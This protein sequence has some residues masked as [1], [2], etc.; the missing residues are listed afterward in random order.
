MRIAILGAGVAGLTCAHIL[1]REHEVTVFEAQ[2]RVGGHTHTHD[3]E[4]EGQ[5][6]RV[7]TGF[8]VFNEPNYPTFLRLLNAL[9]VR[10]RETDMSFSVRCD[11]TGVEWRGSNLNTLFAQRLNLLRPSFLGM[12]RDA[13]RFNRE[14]RALATTPPDD[15]LTVGRFIEQGRYG[16]G[17]LDLYLGPLGSSLWSCPPDRFREFPIR[18]VIDFLHNHDMLRFQGQPVWRTI[19]GGSDS[20]IEPLTR[21]Y[22]ERIRT[23]A[24]VTRVRRD[25][26]GVDV[27]STGGPGRYDELVL[28]CHADEAAAVLADADAGEREMLAAFPYQLNDVVLHT[29]PTLMPRR[30][31][32]WAA[33]NYHVRRGEDQPATVTYSMNIL[34]GI[35]SRR[36]LLVT[37]NETGS[38]EPSRVLRRMRYH[39][40]LYT[41][42]RSSTQARH[43]QFIRRRR[44]SFCGA[45][46]GFGFHED[47]VASAARVAQGFGLTL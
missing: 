4:V 39:H 11:R 15:S 6:H 9:G 43:A 17:F 5:R 34:Q 2:P 33:W 20:Y 13:L 7:D 37:L 38:I 19:V 36:P 41:R 18:F 45:Y 40:P 28:A 47:G 16:R 44:T 29:D 21:P 14:A 46:W 8:I 27:E 10:W 24:A 23:G 26:S 32:A 1:S 30:G 25:E 31:L 3:V 35:Q 42:Q 12:L 22:R